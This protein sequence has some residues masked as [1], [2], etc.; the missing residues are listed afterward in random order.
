MQYLS[1]AERE[2]LRAAIATA[3]ERADAA[4]PLAWL[5]ME[6]DGDRAEVRMTTWPGGV[7]RRIAR[8]GYHGNVVELAGLEEA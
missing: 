8:A 5:R 6:P 4:A 3:G 1:P 2:D 7:D